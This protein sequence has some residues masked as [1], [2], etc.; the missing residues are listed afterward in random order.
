MRID[1]RRLDAIREDRSELENHYIDEL[2]T[3]RVGRREFLRR[4]AALGMSAGVMGAVLSACGGANK[5]GGA[6]TSST[7][8]ATSSAAASKGGTLKLASQVPAAAINPLTISDSGGLCMIAQTGEFLAFDN[9]QALQLQPMLATSWKA[10]SGGSVWTFDIRKGVKFHDG[11][12]LTADDVVWTIQQ[13]ADKKN[14]SNALSTFEGVIT[15]DGVRKVDSHTVAFH[16][17]A[18][19]GN[20]PYLVSSDNYNAIIVPKGTDWSKWQKTFVGTGPFKLGS[21]TQNQGATF[22]ANPD[23]WGGKPNLDSA[24]FSFYSSQSPQI[25]A[26]SSGNVDVIVQFVAQGAEALTK[27]SNYNIIKLKSSNHRELSMRCDQ[28]PFTDPRVRQAIALSLDRPAM[29][30]ALLQSLGQVGND[31]PFAPS[32]PSTDT[33]VPQRMQNIAKAKQLLSAA[34]HSKISTTLYTEQYEEIPALAQ[35]IAQAASKIGVDIKLKVETQSA[36]YGKATYGQSDWLDGQ[37]SL[38]DYGDRGVPNVFLDA[39]LTSGGPW[40]A[41]HFKNPKYDALVKQYTAAVDLSTQ[42]TIAG[43]IETLLL[44]ETPLVIP[45]F[46]DGLSAT[47]KQVSGVAPT[48]IS[49][50]FLHKASISQA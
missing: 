41:A 35:V 23:Y 7:S 32:Y 5:T 42:R 4:G 27:S 16:L 19:N 17:E 30:T 2:V 22:V 31:S 45:Y 11:S 43:K 37:M 25:T 15:P 8:A 39:P 29:V 20:F 14:A 12:P 28:A 50:V 21:Y 24:V 36:Y 1:S 40:N 47:T 46:I 48:S 44:A 33:S 3:G 34:G 18:P 49:Q 6:A 9:N 10:S 38:V 26:L 13:L